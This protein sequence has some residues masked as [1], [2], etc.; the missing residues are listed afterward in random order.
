MFKGRRQKFNRVLE[1]LVEANKQGQPVLIGTASVESSEVFSR[2]LKRANIRHTVLNAKFHEKEAEIVAQAGQKGAVTI[3]TNMAGRGTDIK[4]GEG[5]KE[6]GGLLV[7]GTERHESRRIDRQLRGRCARQGDPGGSRFYVSLEDD[8]MRLFANQGALAKMLEKSFG[9][10]DMLEHGTLDWSIQN[11]Q[12]KVEQQNYSIRKRLLQYDDVLNRQREIVYSIRND[13]LLEEEPSKIIF[14]LVEEELDSRLA[15]VPLEEFGVEDTNQMPQLESLIASWVNVTFPLSVK[16]EEFTGKSFEEA[17]EHLFEKIKTAYG[18]KRK[19]EDPDQ[20]LSLE[21][22]VVVN[23]VDVHWQDHLTEMEELRRSVGLRGYGQKDPL[24][25]YKN[26][27]FRAFEEMMG[28]MRSEVCTGLFRSSTNLA[29]FENMLSSLS[30]VAKT[31]GPESGNAGFDNF[32]GGQ[33]GPAAGQQ[34]S[35]APQI[36]TPVVREA[37]KVGRNDPCPCGS[38]KKYKKCCGAGVTA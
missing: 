18:A 3:A 27:A 33:G 10:D 36:A 31:T 16:L 38:G 4:L 19:L 22:Y 29:A 37:P 34:E 2:M 28:G 6:L 24:S 17:R 9:D 1:D 26:E 14:E 8:L 21:R 11:A 23:A 32:K 15:T 30:G 20:I 7:L 25:E 5:V 13:V 12:K 35:E